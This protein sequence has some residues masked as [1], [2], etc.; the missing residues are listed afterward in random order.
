MC[1]GIWVGGGGNGL[2]VLLIRIST[3]AAQPHFMADQEVIKHTKKVYKIW[4][5]N[6]HSFWHKL[7]EFVIE[8][9]IIVFAVTLSIWLH[10]RSEHAHQ[11]KEVKEFLLGLRQDLLSDIKEMKDDRQSYIMQGKAFNYIYNV[12]M[13]GTIERDSLNRYQSWLFNTTRLQQNNGRFEGFKSSGR[14]GNIEDE[15]LQNNIM[16]L[17]QENIPSLLSSTDAYLQW[18]NQLFV[19]GARN[20]KRLTDSTYNTPAMLLEDEGH[21]LAGYLARPNEI[22]D[23]Y[24]VCIEKMEAIVKE[25]EEKYGIKE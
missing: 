20:R 25:I 13:G 6:T 24:D 7:Q 19:F 12:K 3:L 9:L 17:Y 23:R 11:Q 2:F 14:I 18:K 22:I 8:I 21:N 16:D 5:S 10:D 4:S 1:I 15:K